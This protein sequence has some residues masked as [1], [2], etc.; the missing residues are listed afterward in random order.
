MLE[1]FRRDEARN[2]LHTRMELGLV[3]LAGIAAIYF[4]WNYE[5]KKNAA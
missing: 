4:F 3:L 5:V 2:I 1:Q